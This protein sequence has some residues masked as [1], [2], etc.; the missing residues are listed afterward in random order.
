MIEI[1]QDVL[2]FSFPS[3]AAEIESLLDAY[4]V[5]VL[6]SFFAEDREKVIEELLGTYR[7][8]DMSSE[9][10][11]RVRSI[12]RGTSNED[13]EK[14]LRKD[15]RRHLGFDGYHTLGRVDITFQRTLRI[16]DDRKTYHLPPGIGRFPLRHVDD[17]ADR[18]PLEWIK[19]GGVLMPMYQAE[20]LWLD[21]SGAYP[22]AIKIAAGKIN[23][24]SGE[25]WKEGL[26]SKPQDYV[27]I[28][29]QPWLDG[30]AVGKGVIRQFVAMPLGAG[31]SVEEQLSGKAEFGGMQF[32]V[33]PMK[34][35]KYFESEVRSKLPNRLVDILG[36]LIPASEIHCDYSR[37]SPDMG[38]GAGGRMRQQ[39]FKDPYSLEDWD[40]QQTS[41]CFVHLCDAMLWREITGENPPQTPV[42]ARE[43][44]MAGL[45]WFDF[46]RSDLAVLQGSKTLAGIQSV[47]SISLNKGE[48][49]LSGNKSVEVPNVINLS[50][51]PKKVK[52]WTGDLPFSKAQ[53]LWQAIRDLTRS[54]K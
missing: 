35:R 1:H 42:T 30:F 8:L 2:R 23:A 34:A 6:P 51:S 54:L 48:L 28:P 26:N 47:N 36:D 40:M 31:H 53:K 13:I 43:Y 15:V 24:V 41:R 45:P 7:A 22:F 39:I 17:F 49:G 27:V 3:I 50:P 16:P 29:E 25:S 10:Q 19:R 14:L 12:V 21:F 5:D 4:V 46:Y 33:I 52:E 37:Y 20:A 9:N 44:E 38:L 32:Q 11:E 18:V